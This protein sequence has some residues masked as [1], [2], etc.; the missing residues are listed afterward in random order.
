MTVSFLSV[1]PV[2]LLSFKHTVLYCTVLPNFHEIRMKIT[3]WD[4]I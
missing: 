2:L 4:K 3:P 1:V